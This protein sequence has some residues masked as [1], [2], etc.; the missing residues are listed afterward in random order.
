M[1][2]HNVDFPVARTIDSLGRVV[3]PANMRH[4][5][6]IRRGDKLVLQPDQDLIQLY[7]LDA[8]CAFCRSIEIAARFRSRGICGECQTELGLMGLDRPGP[9][10][11]ERRLRS[12]HDIM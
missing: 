12:T 11:T 7:K 8:R 9:A 1:S 6:G 2:N 10:E 5:F 3:I 4:H